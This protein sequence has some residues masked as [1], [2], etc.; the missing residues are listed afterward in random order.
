LVIAGD[1]GARLTVGPG[2]VVL[3]TMN[4]YTGSLFIGA[5]IDGAASLPLNGTLGENTTVHAERLTVASVPDVGGDMVLFGSEIHLDAQEI[6]QGG[7]ATMVARG[8]DQI[9]DAD[10]SGDVVVS[11]DGVTI[12]ASEG[13]LLAG[14]GITNSEGLVLEFGGG[15]FQLAVA[16]DRQDDA[17]ISPASNITSV[18]LRDNASAFLQALG[19]GDL[20]SVQVTLFDGG[21]DLLS[22]DMLGVIDLALFEEDLSLFGRTGEGVALDFTQ[23]ETEAGCAP[24]VEQEELEANIQSVADR[25]AELEERLASTDDPEEREQLQQMLAELEEEEEE[26]VASL[27]DLEEFVGAEEGMDELEEMAEMDEVDPE[28]LEAEIGVIRSLHNRAQFL[29]SLERSSDRRERYAERAGIELSKE[30]LQEII[31]HTRSFIDRAEASVERML[32]G[33]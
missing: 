16:V 13:A 8:G 15:D 1:N 10:G 25:R 22:L 26:L 6:N 2:D 29:E 11:R 21:T 28:E 17:N 24:Q 12:N 3:P 30:R 4:N 9:G 14:G 18:D 32:G 7:N 20:E 33:G 27:E 19:L 23:C 31:Q 5:D